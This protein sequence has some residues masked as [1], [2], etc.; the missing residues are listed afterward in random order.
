MSRAE[1]AAWVSSAQDFDEDDYDG[2]TQT[3]TT[4]NATDE[5]NWDAFVKLATKKILSSKTKERVNFLNDKV[6]VVAHRGDQ[7]QSQIHDILGIIANTYARY[8]DGPSR[9]AIIAVLEA[10]IRRDESK[11]DEPKYGIA[12]YLLGWL[13]AEIPRAVVRSASDQFVLLTWCAKLYDIL[14]DCN[15]TF[16]DTPHWSI[17][18]SLFATILDSV[19]DDSSNAKPTVR[20]SS[21]VHS[22]RA[23]RN[24][25]N[26]IPKA[27][28]S[29]LK[30]V[31]A[32]S[33]PTRF[34]PFI[35]L[36]IDVGIR[37][38]PS[39]NITINVQD[40]LQE[41]KGP[42][43]NFYVNHI[44]GSKSSL[45]RQTTSA[46][47]DFFRNIV[48][49]DDFSSALLPG[50]EQALSRGT[51]AAAEA[52]AALLRAFPHQIPNDTLTRLIA[53]ILSSL[54]STNT[55]TRSATSS[56]L[57]HL[58]DRLPSESD[59]KPAVSE[60]LA[61]LKGGKT[62]G[63]DHRI[64]LY[65]ILASIKPSNAIS[66]D[67]TTTAL[68][69]LVKETNEGVLSS[70]E[71]AV[72]AHF[73]FVVGQGSKLPTE[74]TTLLAK[75]MASLK[76]IVR[77]ALS[78]IVGQAF[79]FQ[80]SPPN[81]DSKA[82]LESLGK[83]VA[84]V[85]QTYLKA[86][87]TNALN[88]PAGPREGYVAVS[89]LLK[90]A[91]L[92]CFKDIVAKNTTLQ[93]IPVPSAKPSF[94]IWDKVYQ[95]LTDP[96]DEMWLIRALEVAVR[97]YRG[98]LKQNEPLRCV[99][100]MAF[101]N[102][103][104]AHVGKT[105]LLF[106]AAFIHIATQSVHLE[107]RKELLKTAQ[108]SLD[109]DA[110]AMHAMIREAAAQGLQSTASVE[111]SDKDTNPSKSR[112]T[113]LLNAISTFPDTV[114][115]DA[116][117][118]ILTQWVIIAH[119]SLVVISPRQNWVE[120]T[121]HA[122]LDPN[123]L[124]IE[125]LDTLLTLILECSGET[126]LAE[127]A[128]IA[129]ATIAFVAP[130]VAVDRLVGQ[131]KSDLK[132]ELRGLGPED[133]AIWRAPEGTPYVDVLAGKTAS[134]SQPPKK[135][136]NQSIEQWEAELKQSLK[137]K[138][139][140]STLSK[141]DR[142]LV[143]AQLAKESS[144]R[145][146]ISSIQRHLSRG[147]SFVRSLVAANV[148]EL[149]THIASIANILLQ[150]VLP[151]ATEL[152]GPEGFDTYLKS[153]T[154]SFKDLGKSCS[155]RLETFNVWI[156]VATLRSFD[157]PIVPEEMQ[158]EPLEHLVQRVIYRLRSLS[159][160]SPFDPATYSYMSPFVN[161]VIRNGGVGA[162]DQEAMLEQVGLAL[163]I[164]DFHTGSCENTSFPR[165]DMAEILIFAIGKYSIFSKD[166][167]SSL[168]T[169]GQAIQS[170]ATLTDISV[171]V[172]GTLAD[173][174]YVRNA[175]L[176][177]SQ[178]LDITDLDWS[179]E[180]W[181]AIHDEDEQ[182]ARMALHLWEENGFDVPESFFD[183]LVEFLSHQHNYVRRTAPIAVSEA[184]SLYPKT[185]SPIAKRLR[186]LWKEKSQERVPK[187]DEFGIL[188]DDKKI[189]DW[190]A[191]IAI[192]RTYEHLASS[193]NQED[194]VPFFN[195]LI[196]DKA[197]GDSNSEVRRAILNAGI[198]V[199]D[200][201]GAK[202]LSGLINLFESY[203]KKGSGADDT[204]KEALVILL[205]RVARH[206]PKGDPRMK[207]VVDRLVTALKT[208]SEVVQ[209]A[210][211]DCLPPLVVRTKSDAPKLLGRLLTELVQAPKYG[212]RRGAAFGVAGA[213]KGLGLASLQ[214]YDVLG[215]ISAAIDDKKYFEARQGALFAIET[216][217]STLGR[218][219]EPYVIELLPLLLT[220]FGDSTPDVREAT[221]DACKVIMANMSGYG[222]K[223]ILPKLLEG[224]DD[225]Q[226][227]SKKGSIELLGTMAFCAPKQLAVS[228]P[229]VVPRLTDV[230]KDSHTQVRQ[231]ASKSLKQFSEVISNPEIR[232][233]VPTLQTALVDPE[234]TTDA[235]KALLD[236]TFVHYVDNA[237]LAI[238]IPILES[239]LKSRISDA[240]RMAVQI[241]GNMASLTDSKD[242]VPHLDVLLPLIHR[243][244]VDPVPDV[245]GAAAKSLG[246]LVERL[247]ENTFPDLVPGLLQTL[248]SETSAIDRQ[249]A[250][251]GLSEVLS[252]LGME[253][254]E[255]LLPNIIESARS[256][257]PF[258][259]EGFMSLLVFLP[260]TFG[261][262]FAPYLGRIVQPILDGLSD[263][264][265]LVRAASIKAGRI[266]I[267][268]FSSKATD[269][270]LPHLEKSMF[271]ESARIRLSSLT[272]VGE[273]LYKLAGISGKVTT[274]EEEE[275]ETNVAE[276]TRRVLSEVLGKERRDRVLAVL[277]IARQDAVSSVRLASSHIWKA[278][279]NNTPR[280]IRDVLSSLV[281]EIIVLLAT[282]GSEQQETAA[283]TMSE[284]CRKFGDKVLG[285]IVGLLRVAVQSPDSQTR[286]GACMAIS[287]V[288][289]NTTEENM[290]DHEG[291]II[292]VVR[293]CLVDESSSVRV[294][295]ASAFDALQKHIGTKAIDQT[296]P[297][298]LGALRQAGPG[299]DTAL[300]ALKE[301]MTVRS[302]TV[303]P[304]LIPTLITTPITAFNASALAQLV[305]VA[306]DALSKRLGQIL[307]ALVQSIETEED[308]EVKEAVQEA[309]RRLFESV[310]D[311][312]G[313]DNL[314]TLLL[315][316]AKSN[317]PRRRVSGLQ[318]F[319]VFCEATEQ[320][321]SIYR[322]EWI[323]TMV[324]LLDDPVPDVIEASI[325]AFD[326]FIKAVGKED[327]EPLVVPLRKTIEITGSPGQHVPGFTS[328][329]LAS[330]VPVILAGL[331]G[332]TSDQREHAAYAISELVPRTDEAAI[333]PYMTHLTGPLIRVMTQATTLP[334]G[335]K[336]AILAALTTMLEVVPTF[337]KPYFPQ[338]QR[339]FCKSLV[340]PASLAVRT[341]AANALGAL[342]K[343]QPRVDPLVT[344]LV[345]VVR[346]SE[347]DAAA[348]SVYLG[349]AKV[350]S[351]AKE[352]LGSGSRRLLEEVI[353]EAFSGEHDVDFYG[354]VSQ[355]FTA[356]A[357][358][359][360]A[361]RELVGAAAETTW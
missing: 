256:P 243:I 282:A 190:Q 169:L 186:A 255:G 342:F 170:N 168:I 14:L 260:I 142:A 350:V 137:A 230:L 18:I 229:T 220:T 30:L 67:I 63:P 69:L 222:V 86:M 245:R 359:I 140:G 349:L 45:P 269:L 79:W 42:V 361:V 54:K 321:F 136:K 110:G 90:W 60:I 339:T 40:S 340:D 11:T 121:Q 218:I 323:R 278:L 7:S 105:R 295:A 251:Q 130:S 113:T 74:V 71:E 195:F 3:Q 183:D 336:S 270:L 199:V 77:R 284:L 263:M 348:A 214:K 72:A 357:F 290:E 22:R 129:A 116:R 346:T 277:F 126:Q 300:Q 73:V 315:E 85:L 149:Q 156:G 299:S 31:E 127:A 328:K 331:T 24:H 128:Y 281:D 288:I 353:E 6:L 358:D 207:G 292:S 9:E 21:L 201:K 360:E 2:E 26:V 345:G 268:N 139:A 122:R 104:G 177:S 1:I 175:C 332:G 16:P 106:G 275:V 316:W 209:S 173:E 312:D 120:M 153:P 151:K 271:D 8:V 57:L 5:E 43:L 111:A 37:I 155:R 272:L 65:K 227:R 304:V 133:Y 38:K 49:E 202:S 189:D 109:V 334:P 239:G 234:T 138:K 212:E 52:S 206:L 50:I 198:A 44:L 89:I 311:D 143:D 351:S 313:L 285:E 182:N 194:V 215:R 327:L 61:L 25:P 165:Q 246:T 242:F 119:H 125:H 308:E 12:E 319:A 91:E 148:E 146:R 160:A 181:T 55:E 330:M 298:L 66:L 228:L 159:E 343:P 53:P 46:F 114:P 13:K 47:D 82:T 4:N 48:G 259:R 356:L 115:S 20:S 62:T 249:G 314:M 184:V 335:V 87:S 235:L 262:R 84:P 244:L 152:I 39:K 134:A 305:V 232:E 51:P 124:V 341:R 35:G 10:F 293:S 324:M 180:L 172:R 15:A 250:A 253:R 76:I 187:Y 101:A 306:G 210:V 254:M 78:N 219:F 193:F 41:S 329:A 27:L 131:I 174:V 163:N 200:H 145:K 252:G 70:I 217:S 333:K 154:H 93:A 92:S 236:T 178:P 301:I 240:K 157:I 267:N 258:V 132:Q 325:G 208:P 23:V 248:K 161:H 261:Q 135:G 144:I 274:E 32:S 296:I 150:D 99:G 147:L 322:V 98:E 188:I 280:T 320:D 213:V 33:S 34:A 83:T 196:T 112:F 191:R 94:L 197:L 123:K 96:V 166:A 238:V 352:N 97:Q 192:A 287:E 118:D 247:G 303:F 294:A 224:L 28:S 279:V 264:E 318:L 344:E 347:D 68:P 59:V 286:E 257:R 307:N 211:A 355:L 302:T 317:V 326:A 265:E 58:A 205:G 226:W 223:L 100:A 276:P 17:L 309:V 103:A 179:P 289:E 216:L 354:S 167:S 80:S 231:A 297:T 291:Q 204:V 203:L 81:A 185:S 266:I 117:Q 237:S 221:E 337:V 162:S 75:E 29:S 95:K 273:L 107:S 233:L 225:K 88:A 158:Q 102:R 164:L 241:V 56:L 19:L 283:N 338:L 171:L 176:Q 310:E 108:A 36:V 64:A 141:E